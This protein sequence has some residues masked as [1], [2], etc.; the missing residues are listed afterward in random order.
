MIGPR[1]NCVAKCQRS[2]AT[3]PDSR[4]LQAQHSLSTLRELPRRGIW[5]TVAPSYLDNR[6]SH[7]DLCGKLLPR[8]GSVD[9][10]LGR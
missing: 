1:R 3:S 6:M 4:V 10:C 5:H 8:Q 2:V 9:E 7:C